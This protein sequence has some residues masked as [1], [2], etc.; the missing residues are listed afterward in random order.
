M[1]TYEE[2]QLEHEP[3][4]GPCCRCETT[5]GVH[6][7]VMLARRCAVPGHGWGCVVCGLP[8]DGASAVLCDPCVVRW[9]AAPALLTI[10]CRGY[11]GTDGRSPIAE[12]PPGEFKHDKGVDHGC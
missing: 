4:L 3:K 11:P 2:Y 5:E 10:A 12:L 9:Q 6:A 8:S 1:T 7:I